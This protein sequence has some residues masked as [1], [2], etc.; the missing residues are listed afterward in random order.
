MD[1][2][3]ISESSAVKFALLLSNAC[4]NG[5]Q[6]IWPLTFIPILQIIF[7]NSLKA[8]KEESTSIEAARDVWSTG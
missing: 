7:S 3:A 5:T 6:R 8:M 4:Q 2:S 1:F